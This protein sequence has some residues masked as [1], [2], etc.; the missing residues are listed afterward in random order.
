MSISIVVD[1]SDFTDAFRRLKPLIDFD[2]YALMSEIGSQGESQ[3][4]DRV[5]MDKTSPDG[6]PWLPNTTGTPILVKDGGLV[7][8]LSSRASNTEAEWGA[9]QEYA[10]VHQNGMTI[11]PKNKKALQFKIGNQVITVKS[12]T[13]PAR[14]FIGLS[15][16][17][18][19]EIIDL[20]TD[21]F[22]A[23]Q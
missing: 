11:I 5:L 17:N 18:R 8:S 14:P 23:L 2:A 15:E 19:Q 20:V 12:V 1:T 10:H 9:S 16:E 13:I 21:F 22:G 3:T 7:G 4:R 6:A